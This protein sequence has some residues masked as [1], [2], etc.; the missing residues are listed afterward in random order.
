MPDRAAPHPGEVD[1]WPALW[2]LCLGFFMVLVDST[3]VS[4]AT[5]ALMGEFDA[6]VSQVVWVTSAYLLA[7]AVPLLVTGRLGDRFG[8]RRIYLLGLAV[9]TAASAWCGLAHSIEALVAARV[10]Q[11]LGAALL[12][13][14][15]M[16]VMTRLFPGERRGRAMAAWGATAGVATLV[17]PLLGGLLLDSVGWEWIFFVNVPVGVLAFVLAVRLVPRF[18]QRAHRFD[19]LGVVLSALGMFLL[20]FGIQEGQTYDWGRIIGWVSVPLLIVAGLVVLGA[21]VAWQAVQRGEPLVPLGLFAHRNFSLANL[22]ITTVGFATIATA[23]PMILYLQSVRGMSPTQAALVLAPSS[24]VT[25]LL[26]RWAGGLVDRLHPRVLATGGLVGLAAGYLLAALT[27]SPGTPLLLLLAPWALIGL[28]SCFVW[29][30]LSVA[31]TRTLPPHAI[32]AGS[33]VYNTTRQVGSVLGSAAIAALIEAR[34]AAHLVGAGG[35]PGGAP[36]SGGGAD[37]AGSGAGGSADGVAAGGEAMAHAGGQ[38]PPVVADAMSAALREAM[39]LP[40]AVLV[41]GAL[42]AVCLVAHRDENAPTA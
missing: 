41:L 37:S 35:A 28:S 22:A 9:F 36:A 3:I 31:A 24:V 12:S 10:V 6:T 16:A 8:P 40:A 18:E 1:P 42:A 30:P 38:V 23:F 26:A 21:F 17:G 4:I 25:M 15:T 19:G 2:A 13:P 34:M 33:G 14:Q 5:P 11:G 39:L 7:Y 29:A 27:I 32:G 20:V